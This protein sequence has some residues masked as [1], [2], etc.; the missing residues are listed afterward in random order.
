MEGEIE[1]TKWS[2][3]KTGFLVTI[4]QKRLFGERSFTDFFVFYANGQLAFELEAYTQ[5]FKTISIEGILRTYL[6]KRSGIWKTTIEVVKIMKPNSKVMI[7][8]QES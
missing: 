2:H 4:K 7:D 1:S 8:Y 6:E 5:K 3:K